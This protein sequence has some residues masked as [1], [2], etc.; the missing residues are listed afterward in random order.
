M[1]VREE[2]MACTLLLKACDEVP[3][4]S[5]LVVVTYRR[6]FGCDLEEWNLMVV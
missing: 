2:R 6:H 1:I 4:G 5:C 3:E